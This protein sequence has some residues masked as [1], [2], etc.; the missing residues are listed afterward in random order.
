MTTSIFDQTHETRRT[1]HMMK[2]CRV[3]RFGPPS[4][5]TLEDV[6]RLEPGEG[7]VL[8]K[9]HASGVGPWDAWIRAGRS[10]LPQPLPLTLGS[11]VSGTVA[12]LGP[13]VSKFT[14]GDAVF[15]VTNKRF[16]DGYAEYALASAGM[17]AIK[18][19]RLAHVDAA[20]LP[21]VAVTAWQAL[22]DHAHISNGRT[23][24][25]HGAAGNVGTYAVQFARAAGARVIAAASTADHAYLR[26]MGASDVV[27][28]RAEGFEDKMNPVDAVIDLVGGELQA[29]S[30]SIIKPGGTLVSAVSRPDPTLA[31]A[32]NVTAKFFFVDVTTDLLGQIAAEVV[33]GRIVTQIGAILPLAGARTAHEIL[34]GSH[35][36]LRGK[37]VLRVVP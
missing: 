29:R 19:D 8:V 6:P 37:I 33:A 16:T 23:V 17:L 28:A 24:L 20:S 25:I 22:F 11:D 13:S 30:F 14:P 2:A 35:P 32:H 27:D 1:S 4:V 5:I 7:E 21:V 31:A 3:H 12:A 26:S 9:V 10:L 34:E 36:R 18:P 15:G